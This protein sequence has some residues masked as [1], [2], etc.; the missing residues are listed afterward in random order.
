[1]IMETQLSPSF[2]LAEFTASQ[3]AAR[4]G[5]DNTPPASVLPSLKHVAAM[6]DGVRTLVFKNA[7]IIIT[8]GYRCKALND[9]IPGS[10]PTSAHVL[11]TLAGAAV[12]RTHHVAA[13]IAMRR[14]LLHLQPQAE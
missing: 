6:M 7:P 1:V 13:A 10:S 4:L 2:A 14:A 9:Q 3:T 12:L 11:A 5:I 8:S